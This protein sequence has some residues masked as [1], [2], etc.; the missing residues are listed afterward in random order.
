MC[1]IVGFIGKDRKDNTVA[2]MLSV[3]ASFT[4]Y[5]MIKVFTRAVGWAILWLR[6]AP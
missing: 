3:Q 2:K 6:D 4:V 1:G 5:L